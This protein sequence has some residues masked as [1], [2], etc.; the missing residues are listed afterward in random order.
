MGVTA[1]RYGQG[2]LVVDER[3]LDV[4]A[5]RL[6]SGGVVIT[7]E[8][9]GPAGAVTGSGWVLFGLDGQMVASNPH[10]RQQM[11]VP[12]LAEGH[13]LR[14]TL[15][16][17]LPEVREGPEVRTATGVAAVGAVRSVPAATR[18]GSGQ[19]PEGC[20]VTLP[21]HIADSV[22]SNSPLGAPTIPDDY[23]GL[24]IEWS[25]VRHWFGRDGNRPV[26]AM[27]NVLAALRRT[28]TTGVLRIGGDSQ[29]GHRFIPGGCCDENTLF[30]GTVTPGMVDAVLEV[31]DQAGWRATV[32]L[33]LRANDP[34]NAADLVAYALAS[35]GG[36]V[37]EGFEVGNEPNGYFTGPTA[38][39][40]YLARVGTYLAVMD[41]EVPIIGPGIS[42]NADV[43]FAGALWAAH[44]R[45]MPYAAWHDYANAPDLGSLLA[46]VKIQQLQARI[47]EMDA[48]VGSGN[49]RMGE[50]NSVGNG[51]LDLVS[52]V[53]GSAAWLADA[54]LAAAQARQRG[55]NVHSW[56]GFYYPDDGRDCW[57]TPFVIR[58]QQAASR[59]LFYA[60]V[61][62]KYAAGRRF[63]PVQTSNASGSLVRTWAVQD[64]VTGRCYAYVMNKAGSGHA[65]TVGVTG[66]RAGTAF[67]NLLD[68]GGCRYGDPLINGSRLQPD[69]TFTWTGIPVGPQ[70]GTSRFEFVL[71]ECS[72]ALIVLP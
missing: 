59:P 23:M 69:G 49:S 25:M 21:G 50:G 7:A 18:P 36:G 3:V 61:L 54:W 56:D 43:A 52:N 64:T 42:E 34:L 39:D 17:D 72:T 22:V 15:V 63:C 38:V 41:P 35:D 40:D 14:V 13:T 70:P 4:A 10:R 16:L 65:G 57:Y 11:D 47:G 46:T 19:R 68:S 6:V 30:S 37:I 66:P 45:R 32:G 62:L 1:G 8:A 12:A 58:R 28:D 51:G 29:D 20:T 27:V 33:N 26:Q 9:R 71:P 24:S 31:A 2:T 53:A 67:L 5:V 60:L 48:V 55:F 44:G